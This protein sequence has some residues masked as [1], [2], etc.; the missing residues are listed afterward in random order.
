MRIYPALWLQVINATVHQYDSLLSLSR[1]VLFAVSTEM[2]C[3]GELLEHEDKAR[4]KNEKEAKLMIQRC[5]YRSQNIM[6]FGV[7]MT[8][9]S[10]G[11]QPCFAYDIR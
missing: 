8:R 6:Q 11:Q 5:R 7:Y 3:K 4:K 10:G 1:S 2:A 9:I